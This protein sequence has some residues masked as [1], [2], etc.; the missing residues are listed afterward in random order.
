M[1]TLLGAPVQQPEAYK[2]LGFGSVLFS[3]LVMCTFNYMFITEVIADSGVVLDYIVVRVV[4]ICL[5]FSFT[6]ISAGRI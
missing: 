6:I 2:V 5:S 3:S 1:A 4:S